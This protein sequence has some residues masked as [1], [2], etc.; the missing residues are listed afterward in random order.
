MR[1]YQP[2]P[3]YDA[4]LLTPFAALGI[5][6]SSRALTHLDYLPLATPAIAPRG[7]LALRVCH[8]LGAYLDDP[9][10]AFDLP[11]APQGTPSQQ[12]LWSALCAIPV[13]DVRTYGQLAQTLG[14]AARAVGGACGKNPIAL[15][16]PCH[17][18]LA[19]DGGLGGFM[20]GKNATPLAIKRWLLAHEG[21]NLSA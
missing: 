18:V 19:A 1:S 3:D 5:R 6:V 12:R 4:C 8:A 21:C 14:T 20:G 13:G 16:I 15:V 2:T 10:S 11:L 17:R 9:R 7:E